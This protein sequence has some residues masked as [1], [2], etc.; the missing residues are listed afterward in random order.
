MA[1]C[2]RLG[3]LVRQSISQSGQ[4]SMASMLNSFRC[5]PS[6]TFLFEF[7]HPIDAFL[8]CLKQKKESL[9]NKRKLVTKTDY[10]ARI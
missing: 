5:I 9:S 6:K 3:S 10:F 7:L 1:F 2:K 8:F 4:V